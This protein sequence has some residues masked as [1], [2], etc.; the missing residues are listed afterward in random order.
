MASTS[1]ATCPHR[2]PTV[3]AGSDRGP[4]YPSA[5]GDLRPRQLLVDP[6]VAGQAEHPLAEDVA[7][8]L[9]RAALDRVGAR[10]E[11]HLAGRPRGPLEAGG[12]GAAHL[13][14]EVDE[15]VGA[16]QV[17]AQL[18]DGLVVLGEAE[19]GDRA[20]RPG[21]AGLAVLRGPD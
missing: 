16:E 19:L 18:V 8:D 9:R 12:V 20:L 21:V 2:G 17:D 15:G 4:G 3:L 6:H 11:E 1:R 13:V 7:H 10:P 14:V 5:A